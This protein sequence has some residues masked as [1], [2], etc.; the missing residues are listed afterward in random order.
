MHCHWPLSLWFYFVAALLI[1]TAIIAL[2]V[3]Y[4]RQHKLVMRKLVELTLAAS[5]WLL[6]QM[7]HPNF[8]FQNIGIG[9]FSDADMLTKPMTDET[10]DKDVKGFLMRAYIFN[11]FYALGNSKDN[12][13]EYAFGKLKANFKS[14]IK[15][16][17][18]ELFSELFELIA[19]CR[20]F[21][22]VPSVSL[23]GM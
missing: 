11:K 8:H 21:N 3:Q 23:G 17:F 18:S 10:A 5:V 1:S 9:L 7:S 4:A 2:H 14:P 22:V 6:P 20:K 12:P 19:A 16:I 15:I 13:K